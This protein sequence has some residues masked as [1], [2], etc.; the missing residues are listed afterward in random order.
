MALLDL[1]LFQITILKEEKKRVMNVRHFKYNYD[2]TESGFCFFL[3]K[4]SELTRRDKVNLTEG[5]VS[6]S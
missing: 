1:P 4:R 5:D 2:Y 3:I 6:L